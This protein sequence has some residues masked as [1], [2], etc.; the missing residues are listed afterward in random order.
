MDPTLASEPPSLPPAEAAAAYLA[1]EADGSYRTSPQRRKWWGRPFP[2]LAYHSQFARIVFHS[3]WL[4]KRGHYDDVAW[5]KSS[6]AVVRALERVGV[7]FEITGIDHLHG[8]RPPFLV[9][10]NHMSTLETTCLPCMILPRPVTFVVKESLLEYPVFKHVMRSR[11]PI[12]VTQTNP[13]QDLKAMLE[14]GLERLERGISLVVFPEGERT[15]KFERRRFNSIGVKLASRGG[16][17]I[18]P[19]AID[20]RAWGRGRYFSDLGKIDPSRNVHFAFGPPLEVSGR[21]TDEHTAIVDFI[22]AHLNRWDPQHE[23]HVA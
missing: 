1:A 16:V 13:R 15:A 4:A 21:G 17:P 14:G 10:A 5:S 11:D 18:V 12:A 3:A 19:L 7:H 6:L 20:S 23:I 22:Q 8:A 2:S 9:V